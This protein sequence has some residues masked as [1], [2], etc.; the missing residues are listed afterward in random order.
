VTRGRLAGGVD[1]R[2]GQ[3]H[4]LDLDPAVERLVDASVAGLD[5][6]LC[7]AEALPA[8]RLAATPR[9]TR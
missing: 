5:L 6:E 8:M 2:L 3:R 7:L 9:L 4:D 1:L